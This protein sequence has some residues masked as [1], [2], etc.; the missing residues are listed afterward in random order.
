[1]DECTKAETGVGAS[2]A[3]GSQGEKGNCALLVIA[4]SKVAIARG[5]DGV[6]NGMFQ[7][8]VLNVAAIPAIN[9]T[10]PIR[11]VKAVISP[12]PSEEGVW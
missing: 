11:L 4:A 12:A 10:S 5:A 2:I 6:R 7:C 1:M 9:A 8:A 3:I